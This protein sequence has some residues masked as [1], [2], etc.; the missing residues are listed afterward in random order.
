MATH[1]RG[2]P[3]LF[4]RAYPHR[5]TQVP[6]RRCS[7]LVL[8]NSSRYGPG[9][10]DRAPLAPAQ[11]ADIVQSLAYA[12]R[13]NR[14]GKRVSDRDIMTSQ[15]AAEHL[16]EALNRAGYVIMK[17]PPLPAHSVPPPPHAHL[18]EPERFPPPDDSGT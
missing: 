2:A 4:G 6:K 1:S 9:M 8:E 17:H 18:Y 10:T 15:D 12:L 13:Y 14:A 5:S 3:F 16:I 7:C 11:H